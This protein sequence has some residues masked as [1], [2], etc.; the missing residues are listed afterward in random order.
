MSD[1]VY[2]PPAKPY[3]SKEQIDKW[4]KDFSKDVKEARDLCVS[5]GLT[6]DEL[7]KEVITMSVSR[8]PYLRESYEVF[9]DLG[10]HLTALKTNASDQQKVGFRVAQ[11]LGGRL[12]HHRNPKNSHPKP[13]AK[14]E[15]KVHTRGPVSKTF[16]A[17]Q[18]VCDEFERVPDNRITATL[19]LISVQKVEEYQ[20]E[21]EGMGYTFT[22]QDNGW[23]AVANPR[24]TEISLLKDQMAKQQKQ[25]EELQRRLRELGE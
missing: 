19:L 23:I 5:S 2:V 25:M 24:K 7:V 11:V 21:L 14:L 9:S 15:R 1:Q 13:A 12:S 6:G 16:K 22:K 20:E 18:K 3:P 8:Y 4:L 10:G 17:Y